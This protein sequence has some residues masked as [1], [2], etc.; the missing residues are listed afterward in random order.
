MKKSIF[1]LLFLILTVTFAH[2]QLYFNPRPTQ[3]IGNIKIKSTVKLFYDSRIQA[4]DTIY[5]TIKKWNYDPIKN[6]YVATV[7]D[8]T[9]ANNLYTPINE[10][11]KTFQ[12]VEVDGLFSLLGNSI[13]PSESYSSEMDNL[14]TMALLLDTQTN[15]LSD[16][17]T[18]YGGD[19]IHW[20]VV[21]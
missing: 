1:T 15:L 10:K 7:T 17:K 12:K 9:K 2:A 8:Y 6:L 13:I 19:A 5:I 18:V 14:L 3:E 21:P 16:G 11:F 4:S 20:V